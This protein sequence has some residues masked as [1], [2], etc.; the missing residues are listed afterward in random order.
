MS[1]FFFFC[2]EASLR[3]FKNQMKSLCHR[4]ALKEKLR[5][6]RGLCFGF[7]GITKKSDTLYTYSVNSIL[8]MV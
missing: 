5:G 1:G 8:H 2:S 7:P 6:G 4:L 3:K